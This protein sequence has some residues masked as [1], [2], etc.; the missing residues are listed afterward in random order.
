ML[1]EKYQKQISAILRKRLGGEAKFFV[2]GSSLG[3]GMFSDV[4]V[5]ISGDI[6][7]EKAIALAKEDL[8]E[9]HLP[10]KVDLVYLK[11]AD[12][13]FQA[14]LLNEKKIWLI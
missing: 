7:D 4:D 14:K 8:E 12:E 5:A 10:Y 11:K 9:S 13:N 3:E 1:E 2:F 6:F